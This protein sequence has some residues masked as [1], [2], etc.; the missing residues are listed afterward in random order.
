[1]LTPSLSLPPKLCLPVTCANGISFGAVQFNGPLKSA[2][3]I[4]PFFFEIF[5]LSET[6]WSVCIVLYYGSIS[7]IEERVRYD[8]WETGK[9]WK[10]N[11]VGTSEVG[12]DFM[13]NVLWNYDLKCTLW[14]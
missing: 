3:K 5:F 4:I 10:Y 8:T 13:A 9:R 11:G 1:M 6:Y 2:I 12:F 14:K 7:T